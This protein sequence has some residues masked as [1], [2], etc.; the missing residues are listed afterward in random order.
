[1]TTRFILFL[2]SSD[3]NCVSQ[4]FI[5]IFNMN[6]TYYNYYYIFYSHMCLFVIEL[7]YQVYY[8]VLIIILYQLKTEYEEY[9]E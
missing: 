3:S 1:M 4:Y 6:F 7:L 9:L 8:V 5:T 2:Q